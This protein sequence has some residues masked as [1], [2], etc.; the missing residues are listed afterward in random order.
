M[1]QKAKQG[2]RMAMKRMIQRMSLLLFAA[3]V[4]GPAFAQDLYVYPEKGQSHEQI[5]QAKYK[6][7]EWGKQQTGFDPMQAPSATSPPPQQGAQE[8]GAGRGAVRGGMVGLGVGAIAGDAGKGA[9]IGAAS[10]ALFGGMR[11]RDQ[12]RREQQ[13]QEQWAQQQAS[14]YQHQRSQYNR[15]YAACLEGKGYTVR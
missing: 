14:N 13:E 2:R 10:G 6:C 8:G 12:Q 4:A 5:E 7:Y 11:R 9:A 3:L 15:A 1:Y